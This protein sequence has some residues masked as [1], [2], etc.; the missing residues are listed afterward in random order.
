MSRSTIQVMSALINADAE[1]ERGRSVMVLLPSQSVWGHL[2][3]CC[4]EALY[5]DMS[6]HHPREGVY[7]RYTNQ[8]CGLRSVPINVLITVGRDGPNWENDS[9]LMCKEKMRGFRER[10]EI[11]I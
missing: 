3:R 4:V 7:I 8:P 1:A 5:D 10:L 6:V 9:Y 2:V 11:T